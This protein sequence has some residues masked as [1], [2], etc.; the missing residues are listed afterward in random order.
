VVIQE[1]CS[2]SPDF[3]FVQGS[4]VAVG[5]GGEVYV[6]WE[7][8]TGFAATVREIDLRKSNNHGVSFT[9]AVKVADVIEVGDGN[10]FQGGI[11]NSEFPSLGI[12][13]SGTKTKGN[14]YIAWNDGRNLQVPDFEPLNG[15][16]G[17]GD[18]LLSRSTNGGALGLLRS[19]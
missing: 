10:L 11:R 2:P 16:Y 8:F 7:S 15:L 14:L 18:V 17:Y 4:Q 5:P 9:R 12:D 19:A 6:A 1:F 3:P 13:R